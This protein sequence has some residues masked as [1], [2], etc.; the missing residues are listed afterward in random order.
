MQDGG[1][2]V[3]GVDVLGVALA[4]AGALNALP[5]CS[6]SPEGNL[7]KET[8][9]IRPDRSLKAHS[10]EH[11][12]CPRLDTTCAASARWLHGLVDVLDFVG[13][14]ARQAGGEHEAYRASTDNDDVVV[15]GHIG[16]SGL[17]GWRG[18]GR[19][20][21]TG[22]AFF[23]PPK[24]GTKQFQHLLRPDYIRLDMMQP[25]LQW[26]LPALNEL[27]AV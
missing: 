15:V 9:I 26:D 20:E 12:Q 13:P 10:A 16:C 2:R 11:V 21:T 5:I 22:P 14:Q 18:T 27:D 7:L 8:G 17:A 1:E 23:Y 19:G 25:K 3:P 6:C 4:G 24:N